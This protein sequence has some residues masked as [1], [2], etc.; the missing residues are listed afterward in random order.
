[1]ELL[2][3]WTVAGIVAWMLAEAKGR[4]G[5]GWFFLTVLLT[6]LVILILLVLPSK[7]TDPEAATPQTHVR[8]PHCAELVRREA[9]VCKH[10]HG[11]LTPTPAPPAAAARPRH[12]C[13]H[14][15]HPIR[16]TDPR[17]PN[18]GQKTKPA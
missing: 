3:V 17:C 18:C 1:M 14:C 2:I 9:H 11:A 4:S 10:C 15:L 5:V 8:C 7:K 12:E 16:L 6:P 13:P